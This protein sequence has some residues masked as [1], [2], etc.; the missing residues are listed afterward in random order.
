MAARAAALRYLRHPV[1]VTC[2]VVWLIN[3]R[4][5]KHSSPGV[6]TGKLSDLTGLVVFAG[7]AALVV[8]LVVPLQSTR[9]VGIVA[10]VTTATGFTAVKT[11]PAA[12]RAAVALLDHLLGV[13]KITLDPT[14]LVALIALPLAWML[15]CRP[16]RPVMNIVQTSAAWIVAVVALGATTATSCSAVK[17][18]TY[19][20]Q[21]NATTIAFWNVN[22]ADQ[23]ARFSSTDS[24]AHWV[25]TDISRLGGVDSSALTATTTATCVPGALQQ[26]FRVKGDQVLESTDGGHTWKV[27]WKRPATMP[28]KSDATCGG[29]GQLNAPEQILIA[30]AGSSAVIVVG[31]GTDGV[32]RRPVGAATWQVV[33]VLASPA[34]S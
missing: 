34:S 30:G 26:C 8:S 32:L 24:G 6:I 3:D 25:A 33:N 20:W 27:T 14:D 13:A 1:V 31:V 19:L 9:V 7:L 4:W 12:N 18:L 23:S 17:P 10:W 29:G 15:W 16:G 11:L 21:A 2:L 28:R 5:L 22:A